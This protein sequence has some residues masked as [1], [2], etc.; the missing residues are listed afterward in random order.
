[1]SYCVHCGVE[2]DDAAQRCPLCG[3][4]VLD[5]HKL[6]TYGSAPFFP[7]KPTIV[8]PVSKRSLAVLLST[9]LLSVS[10]CCGL[11][12]IVLNPSTPWHLFVLGAAMML[13]IW[14][15]LPLLAQKV[16]LWLRLTTD[17]AAVGM[18]VW[19]IALTLDG[20]FWFKQLAIP[21][22]ILSAVAVNVICLFSRHKHSILST[23]TLVLADVGVYGIGIE[24]IC[25]WFAHQSV[26][27]D[28]SLILFTICLGL[29]IPLMVVRRVPS[30]RAEA[31]RRFHM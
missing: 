21:L 8:A 3:T 22:I 14:V 7:T 24:V 10:V 23:I 2:L 29:C 13:W 28:W 12:N 25:D 20:M 16:P 1:M 27:L 30:L 9:M 15:V 6:T 4:V 31:Q 19:T 17:V 26:S 18:Y 5:P 11:L